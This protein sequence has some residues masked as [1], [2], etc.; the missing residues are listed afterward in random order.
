MR[1]EEVYTTEGVPTR[2][3]VEP[4]NYTELLVD[5]RSPHKPVIIE[6]QSGTGKTTAV[7]KILERESSLAGSKYLTARLSEDLQQ[8]EQLAISAAPGIF[9]I[10]DFHRLAQDLQVRLGDLAKISAEEGGARNLPKL[11]LIGIN[12][13]GSGLI[14]LVP[15]LAKRFGI[16]RIAPAN[17]TVTA[18]LVRSGEA[19]LNVRFKDP[20]DIYA[21]AQGDYWLTQ[22]ICQTSCVMHGVTDYED[23]MTREIALAPQ[24]IRKRIVAR[25]HAS[26]SPAAKEFCRGRRFRPSNDP[27]YKLLRAV[28]EY[29]SSSVDLT[30]LANSRTDIRASILSIRDDRLRVLLEAKPTVARYFY[31]NQTTSVFAIEDPALFYFLRHVDW[32]GFRI[33]CGFRP[34]PSKDFEYD[35]AISFAGENRDLA[36]Y[37]ADTFTDLDVSVFFDEYFENNF[38]GRAWGTEFKRIFTSA[39]RFVAV[40]LDEHH[41]KKIWPTFERECFTPRVADAAVIPIKL[42]DSLFPGI[43]HDIALIRFRYDLHDPDWKKRAESEIVFRIIDRIGD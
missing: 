40:L 27:Y 5:I 28:A 17:A 36:R 4:P 20:A 29:G 18:E 41:L 12:Q 25:L 14:Q 9:I 43:P 7:K 3:F 22:L 33:E 30:M 11:V 10:D 34:G 19:P 35:I 6:G 13:V 32:D 37:L 26:Y 8:I 16:H 31:F 2:T 38:L 23:G 15:D 1:V 42:D 39:C 21:E 24:E